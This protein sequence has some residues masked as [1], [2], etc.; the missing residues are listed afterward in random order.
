M[1]NKL[2][3]LIAIIVSANLVIGQ[4]I[5]D[6]RDGN[7]YQTV[8]IGNQIWMAENLKYLPQV[9][10]PLTGSNNDIEKYYYVYGYEG[11]DTAEAKSTSS[12]NT[13]GVLYNFAAATNGEGY[14]FYN[15]PEQGVCPTGWHLPTDDEWNELRSY[16]GG[17]GYGGKLKAVGSAWDV[18][19][20]NATNETG[21]TALPGGY[22]SDQ[23]LTFLEIYEKGL[24]WSS[25]YHA[26]LSF[27]VA[28]ANILFYNDSIF[29]ATYFEKSSGF[30]V[31]CIKTICD[32]NLNIDTSSV[33]N[34]ICHNDGA[35]FQWLFSSDNVTFS[36]IIGALDS[37]YMPA[38][39]GY[40]AVEVTNGL[41][42]DTTNSYYF[43]DNSGVETNSILNQINVYPNPSKNF[44]NVDLKN[45]YQTSNIYISDLSGRIVSVYYFKNLQTLKI[46]LTPLNSGVYNLTIIS[47]KS[48][49]STK[50]VKE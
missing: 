20:T 21:F 35:T 6:N 48:Y 34:W 1:T 8:T 18:P 3:T 36:H 44:V 10:S 4:S 14:S 33:D 13:Y 27:D 26:G 37:A 15:D 5:I 47:D 29:H 24:W 9:N 46:D 40:Y 22:L 12:Y 31:R 25:S 2:L 17:F 32:L 7:V 38:Q 30:S 19:N 39:T 23:S 42:I 49:Y 11:T 28:Y 43:F 16:I 41:C 50:I 45:N